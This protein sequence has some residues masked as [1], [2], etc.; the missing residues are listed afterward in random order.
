MLSQKIKHKNN[1]RANIH[2]DKNYQDRKHLN[3]IHTLKN[4]LE[5]KLNF[6]VVTPI[7]KG[8]KLNNKIK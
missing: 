8:Q 1:A 2:L 6:Q 7:K 5:N 3:P 4:F